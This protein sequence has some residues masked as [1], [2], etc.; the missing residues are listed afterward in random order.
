MNEGELNTTVNKDKGPQLSCP[1][2]ET[3]CIQ[4]KVAES[5]TPK[6][7]MNGQVVKTTFNLVL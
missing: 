4:N 6:T 1:Q 3:G 5:N 7:L 2:T